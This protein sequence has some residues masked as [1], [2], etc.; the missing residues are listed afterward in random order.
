MQGHAQ[1]Q[2]VQLIMQLHAH[3]M[4]QM[5]MLLIIKELLEIQT[6]AE[7]MQANTISQTTMALNAQLM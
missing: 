4:M 5:A 1:P 6:A 2:A 7:M 3:V